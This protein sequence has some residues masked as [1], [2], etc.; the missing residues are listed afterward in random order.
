[1]PAFK[2][3]TK[4]EKRGRAKKKEE[5]VLRNKAG[6][7]LAFYEARRAARKL[8]TNKLLAALIRD[9]PEAIAFVSAQATIIRDR[10]RAKPKK[11]QI[12]YG[13]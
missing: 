12:F 7:S 9:E 2:R 8:D 3:R 4:A 10:L 11:P 5:R 13:S 6:Y 1:M